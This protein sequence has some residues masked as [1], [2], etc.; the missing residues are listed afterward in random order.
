MPTPD[1]RFSPIEA[2]M[3]AE[4]LPALAIDTFRHYHRLL[5]EGETGLLAEDD[6]SPV[7]NLP[8]AEEFTDALDALGRQHLKQTVFLKLN[9]G[10]G[11]SMG[12]EQAKSLLIVREGLSFLDIIARQ[13]MGAGIPLLLMNSFSTDEDSL[14]ALARWPELAHGDLPLSFLQH[15]VP[16]LTRDT[17]EAASF[18]DDP[19]QAWCP[20]GHGDLYT[21][22]LTSGTLD[23]L[24]SAGFRYAFVSN[25]D[26]LGATLDPALLGHMV[27]H[28]LPFMMEV[29]DRTE[30]D[31]KGGHLALRASDGQLILRERAQC[32]GDA[33]EAFEDIH[34]HRYF[35]T[36][37]IWLDLDA[38]AA[39]LTATDGVLALPM[40]RNA[41]TVDPRDPASTPVYQLETAMGSAIAIFPGAGAVRVP[42]SRFAPVKT[43]SDLLAIRSDA[44]VLTDDHR[45]VLDPERTLPAPV[46]D[47][48]PAFYRK[49]DDLEA[50]FPVGPPSMRLCTHFVVRGDITFGGHVLLEK[51]VEIDAAEEGPRHLDFGT[52]VEGRWRV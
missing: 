29:T 48:D 1:E 17:L 11:T 8:D 19:D 28:R 44:Y 23:K 2:L 41:K 37:N 22:L 32:P 26:N 39:Q 4:G 51:D 50:R 43:T 14:N 33:L 7:I 25:S 3:R 40:I 6:I 20:P 9:G 45:V 46:V 16:K 18:P 5:V 12:L 10:L 52:T 47:L 27:A 15:K 31:K 36:N 35:N 34:R 24:R 21:A 49:I 30:A 13:A 38:L 42:R